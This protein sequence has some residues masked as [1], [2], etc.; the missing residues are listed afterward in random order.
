MR[1]L[2]ASQLFTITGMKYETQ[3]PDAAFV[4]TIVLIRT[5]KYP[6]YLLLTCIIL[7]VGSFY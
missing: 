6:V 4:K 2:V 1:H 7:G 3:P 5:N